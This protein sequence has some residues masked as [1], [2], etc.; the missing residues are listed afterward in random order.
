MNPQAEWLLGLWLN[1]QRVGD[2]GLVKNLVRGAK[3]G[4]VTPAQQKFIEAAAVI[5]L[6]PDDTDRVP[7]GKP[8]IS[9]PQTAQLS[10]RALFPGMEL[11]LVW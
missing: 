4:M 1:M 5:R 7:A 2:I 8:V 11:R 3:A 6:N 10:N 9:S